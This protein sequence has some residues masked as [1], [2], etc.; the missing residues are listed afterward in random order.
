M[1]DKDGGEHGADNGEVLHHEGGGMGGIGG[2]DESG[3]GV[4]EGYC[5]ADEEESDNDGEAKAFFIGFDVFFGVVFAEST[6]D[7]GGG[8]DSDGHRKANEEEKCGG[9]C[10]DGGEGIG[11]EVL[12]EV[13]IEE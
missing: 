11:F 5:G 7:H 3:G 1:D 8:G 2:D 10:A 4:A 9:S 12:D 13:G 6:A